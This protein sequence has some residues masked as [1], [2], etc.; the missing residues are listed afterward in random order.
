[1]DIIVC[2]KQ[3]ADP[4][5]LVEVREGGLDV[6][7]RRVTS[8]FDEVAV[9]QAVQLRDRFGGQVTAITAGSGKAVDA[10]R[11]AIA[12][13]ANRALMVDDPALAAADGVGVARA[14]AAALRDEP[15]DLLICGRVSLDEE[16]GVVGPALAEF[17][18]LPHLSEVVGLE[19]DEDGGALTVQRVVEGG[20][21]ME[22][23][24]LPLLLTAGKGLAEP[25]V[26]P[27]TGVMKAMRAPVE[28]KA[29]VDLGLTAQDVAA[30]W[31][32]QDYAAPPTRPAVQMVAGE[33]PANVATLVAT[34]K[35]KGVLR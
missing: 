30:G 22:Y 20:R 7:D 32:T 31:P 21:A 3:V 26:P 11:R 4:E 23:C 10:V 34:L 16:A 27:V 9:E 29:L 18:G 2:V 5:A 19:A 14:L 15:K 35:D 12:M 25:R 17:L 28:K 24:P 6:E 8:F 13:G 1:M 33:F